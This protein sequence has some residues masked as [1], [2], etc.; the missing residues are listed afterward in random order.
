MPD[1]P[2]TIHRA[3]YRPYPFALEET[4]L[5]FD[6]RDGET[7]V[8][9][10]LSFARRDGAEGDLVLYGVDVE[11]VS[12]AVDGRELGGNEYAV[13]GEALTVFGVPDRC[14]VQVTTKIVPEDNTAFEGLYKSNDMYCTQCEAEGFRKITYYPDRPDV[15]TC[16]TTTISADADRYP[17]LLS[18]GNLVADDTV[19]GRRTVT[20]R[21]PFPKPSYLFALVGG[22][23]AVLEDEFVTRSGRS[24]T[25]RI[26]S[27][28][29]NIGQCDYA[30]GALKR[31]MRWDEERFGREY[32][33]DIFM[34]VAVEDFNMGAM[35]NKGL[36]I[37]NTSYV[38]A[39]ADTAT[40]A[41]HERVEAVVAHEYFHNWSGNR[42]TCRDWF[43]LSLKEGFT[44]YRD[45]EFTSD[46]NSR[47]I[48]RVEDVEFLRSVQFV[49]DAGPLA[50]PV[51]PDSYVEISNFYTTTV[52]EKGAEVV[53]MLDTILGRD[54][55][56][57]GTD[58][59]FARHD[60]Q[61]VTIEDF[62]V[63]MEDANGIE[64]PMFR[65]WYEQAGTPRVAVAETR[66]G[67][68]LE[69]VVEQ[70]SSPSPN[71]PTKQPF[72]IPIAFG[73]VGA[74]GRDMLG[75][76][77]VSAGFSVDV[78]AD[79]ELENPNAD[80]TLVAHLKGPRARLRF[81]GVPSDAAVSFL[82]GFSAPVRVDYPRDRDVRRRLAASDPDGFSRWD[83]AQTLVSSSLLPDASHADRDAVVALF[84]D[85]ATRAL[86]APDDGEAKALLAAMLTLPN[87]GT[88][89]DLAPGADILAITAA[90]DGMADRL[91]GAVDWLA[92]VGANET[93]TS[94]RPDPHDIARR[95]LKLRAL[96]YAV[97]DL[98]RR[99]PGAAHEKLAKLLR[100]ADN[101]T[102]RTAALHGILGLAGLDDGVKARDLEAFYER[103][104]SEALVVDVWLSA[105]ARNPLP[106]GLTRV[107]AL[108]THP[109]FEAT[110]PN[111]IRA[112]IGAYTGN[113]RNFHTVDGGSYRWTAD[114]VLA[115]DAKNPQ[116]A[117]ALAKKLT[118]WPRFDTARGR[119]MRAVLE[120]LGGNELSKDV[121]E[122]VDKGLAVA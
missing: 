56:R 23:L 110:N 120:D 76:A 31:A 87:E 10:E 97:R 94:Y 1:T 93:A 70:S 43:Q 27:E 16:F 116:V 80:G 30:M 91:A 8:V 114:K 29:H 58:T 90:W 113:V 13:S 122:V 100:D 64:L 75:T 34:I 104:S 17:V 33:L 48:K 12:L 42:V 99:D 26:Y 83:A 92:L 82:R 105:Q 57:A 108:E 45:A 101:L 69:L 96:W 21:D 53:R 79:V 32:D 14:R 119:R 47:T 112:L 9:A 35:E 7:T 54:R 41:A 86:D 78:E 60:G 95:S 37:F 40:D 62:V 74:D 22:D 46:M 115:V 111:K 19:D 85:L 3:D 28:P 102:E 72:H 118:E 18:N 59:Y 25:L 38:L 106:G 88:L 51:R 89:L 55:F 6:I 20:W 84:E 109:A 63:A 52:Y 68:T 24:V 81:T 77:G 98:G 49:E 11:L 36:N 103:W 2:E 15:L 71:Q 65:R 107:R 73:L 117:S 39:T 5:A 4:A 50:H 61:A 66:T 121:R 67:D 44:V